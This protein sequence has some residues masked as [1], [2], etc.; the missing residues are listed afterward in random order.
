M[1]HHP[2]PR[3]LPDARE[4]AFGI[5]VAERN[6]EIAALLLENALRTLREAGCAEHNQ[7]VK[8]V[9]ELVDLAMTTQFFAEYTEVDAVIL[10]GCALKGDAQQGMLQPLLQH[11][12]QIQ[13]QWNM[14]CA[15]GVLEAADR[16]TA[17]VNCEFG[18]EAARSA[19]CMVKHQIEMEAAAPKAAADKRNLN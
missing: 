7:Q 15:W 8:F 11:V 19:I 2:S 6:G 16:G 12:L 10:L 9:P 4:M 3:P 17:L 18:A 1:S 14:P 13:M 5:V